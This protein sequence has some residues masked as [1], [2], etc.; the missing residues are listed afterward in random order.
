MTGKGMSFANLKKI[1][2]LALIAALSLGTPAYVYGEGMSPGTPTSL[3]DTAGN[4][5]NGKIKNKKKISHI[6]S[7]IILP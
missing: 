1:M 2:G 4:T 6:V 5:D 3:S 7:R